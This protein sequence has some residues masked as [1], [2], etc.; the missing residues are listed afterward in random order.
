MLNGWPSAPTSRYC[1]GTIDEV[2]NYPTVLTATQVRGQY[3]VGTTGAA[4]AA[5]AIAPDGVVCAD[6]APHAAVSSDGAPDAAVA[7][8]ATGAT[9]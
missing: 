1:N 6:P 5:P 7:P 3:V 8:D 4:A 2:S 9:P